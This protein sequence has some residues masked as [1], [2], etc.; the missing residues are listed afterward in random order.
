MYSIASPSCRRRGWAV[1]LVDR[2]SERKRREGIEDDGSREDLTMT[3]PSRRRSM[4]ALIARAFVAIVWYLHRPL[5]I[6]LL[7]PGSMAYP[8]S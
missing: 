5:Q 3:S 6:Y 2:Y 7:L 1:R 8:C 4:Y